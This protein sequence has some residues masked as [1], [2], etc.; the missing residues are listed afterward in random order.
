MVFRTA[1]EQK[2]Q[3]VK[4][5]LSSIDQQLAIF[6]IE[7]VDLPGSDISI[8]STIIPISPLYKFT[9]AKRTADEKLSC[10]VNL[11]SIC[12]QLVYKHEYII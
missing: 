7:P 2:S 5:S 9:K 6:D 4:G 12:L 11:Y 8:I 10:F 1:L 3:T